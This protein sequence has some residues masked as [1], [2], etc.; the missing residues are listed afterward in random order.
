MEKESKK[1]TFIDDAQE[2]APAKKAE[3]V[4]FDHWFMVKVSQKRKVQAHHY[5]AIWA[6]FK[7]QGLS[8]NEESN[9]FESALKAF[10]Y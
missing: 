5:E 9:D 10:G 2:S 6:F 8:E 1:K 4:N 7:K 3:P